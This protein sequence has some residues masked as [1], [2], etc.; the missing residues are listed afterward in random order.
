MYS[1]TAFAAKHAFYPTG[2]LT[3]EVRSINHRYLEMNLRLPEALRSL[4][5]TLRD[6][7]RQKFSRGKI[8]IMVRFE[9]EASATLSLNLPLAKQLFQYQE[10]LCQNFHVSQATDIHTI[11]SW[12]GVIETT[13]TTDD[14][15]LA[16]CKNLFIETLSELEIMRAKEGQM[17]TQLI[18]QRI[19][20]LQESTEIIAQR[21]P[22]IESQLRARLAN[23]L[24]ELQLTV[25]P[26][27]FDQEVLMYLHKGDIAEELDRLKMHL[28]AVLE[29]CARAGATGK[30]LDFLMQELNREVNTLASKSS[31]TFLSHTVVNMKV[32][33]EE[34]REQIQ[35]IE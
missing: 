19:L 15:F 27:R 33:I 24:K 5:M 3:I 13:H 16:N 12:P 17:I 20:A 23:K 2:N 11:F 34:M 21:L 32:L 22:E 6:C 8:D 7:V 29:S 25:A 26:E 9:P 31:D 30:R 10:Q 35:N 14:T 18:H 1:M 28:Q 4:E